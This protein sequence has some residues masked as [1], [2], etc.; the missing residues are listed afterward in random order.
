MRCIPPIALTAPLLSACILLAASLT[1]CGDSPTDAPGDEHDGAAR[2]GGTRPARGSQGDGGAAVPADRSDGGEAIDASALDASPSDASTSDASG[3]AGELEHVCAGDFVLE[4]E[5]DVA[6]I[7]ECTEISGSLTITGEALSR[8]DLPVLQAVDGDLKVTTTPLHELDLPALERTGGALYVNHNQLLERIAFP[9]LVKTYGTLAIGGFTATSEDFQPA[10]TTLEL[11][12]LVEI[13][14]DDRDD[15][16]GVSAALH[17]EANGALSVI[18]LPSL[19]RVHFQVTIMN[20]DALTEIDL[21]ALVS[22][23]DDV[24]IHE[25]DALVSVRAPVLSEQAGRLFLVQGKALTSIELTALRHAGIVS[26]RSDGD[27]A[28]VELPSLENVESLRIGPTTATQLAFPKLSWIYAM[29]IIQ[30]NALLTSLDLPLL[31]DVGE[32]WDGPNGSDAFGI[33]IKNNAQLASVQMPSL[34]EVGNELL[35]AGNAQFSTCDAQALADQ[36]TTPAAAVTIE[37]N[38]GTCP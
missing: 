29:L 7:A 12:A 2:D 9:A 15:S 33:E 10:L 8:L 6:A 25:N 4:T 30:D 5:A 3:D 34:M 20:D 21:P 28:T 37:G 23:G 17:I 1:G 26:I 32:G 36:L 24:E 14:D 35:I 16:E 27:L 19:Q 13:G 31:H 22:I 18:A 38:A 11:P